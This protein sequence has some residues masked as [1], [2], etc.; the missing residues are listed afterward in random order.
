MGILLGLDKAIYKN[1]K[2]VFKMWYKL[3]ALFMYHRLY[4]FVPKRQCAGA[5]Q[6][7]YKQAV[8]EFYKY[9]VQSRFGQVKYKHS[10]FQL[11]Q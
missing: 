8:F 3:F 2:V 11:L 6:Y 4:N 9:I 5:V 1:A 10:L 7:Q